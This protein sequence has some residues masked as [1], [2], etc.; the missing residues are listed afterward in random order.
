MVLGSAFLLLGIGAFFVLICRLA[1][2]ALP[3]FVGWTVGFW[4]YHTGAGPIGA[5]ILALLAGAATLAVGRLAFSSSHNEAV[6]VIT[7]ALFAAPAMLAGYH[8]VLG[9]G[10]LAVPSDAWQHVFA[11]MGALTIG[12]TAAVRLCDGFDR[13]SAR[14]TR[15]QAI[16]DTE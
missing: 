5:T 3:A 4:A 8:L 15:P 7:I 11:V 14:A 10:R 1:V 2:D 13:A 16:S 6:R 9:L 12:L